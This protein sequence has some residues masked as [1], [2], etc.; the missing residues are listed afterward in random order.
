MHWSL[1]WGKSVAEVQELTSACHQAI[2]IDKTND[3]KAVWHD[4][5][6][7]NKYLLYHKPVKVLPPEH[8]W[9]DWLLNWPSVLKKPRLLTV[10]KDNQKIQNP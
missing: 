10:P 6:H 3:I 8:L 9:H 7:L 1:L 4:N 2:V 5:S